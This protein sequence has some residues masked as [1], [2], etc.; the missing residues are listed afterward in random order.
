[1]TFV[2]H[3]VHLRQ[4]HIHSLSVPS[5]IHQ[6][7]NV[8]NQFIIRCDEG[9]GTWQPNGNVEL[10]ERLIRKQI[11]H[12]IA[13]QTAACHVFVI[14][15]QE[16]SA[17]KSVIDSCALFFVFISLC[18]PS[19]MSGTIEWKNKSERNKRREQKRNEHQLKNEKKLIRWK[20]QQQKM[21][22]AIA[23]RWKG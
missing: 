10:L 1:M 9:L 6:F 15:S 13:G 22:H 21:F 4:A 20:R 18:E 19:T 17:Y 2:W 11:W 23:R 12:V 8:S 7:A 14:K 5:C 16:V 3:L